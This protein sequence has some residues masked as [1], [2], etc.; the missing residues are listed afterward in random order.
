[1]KANQ[2]SAKDLRLGNNLQDEIGNIY[3]VRRLNTEEDDEIK[4][5]PDDYSIKATKAQLLP[6]IQYKAEDLAEMADEFSETNYDEEYEK[7]L[8]AVKKYC[9]FEKL[10]SD[11]PKLWYEMPTEKFTITK[12]DL[13]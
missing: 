10:N 8:E 6:I 7:I 13:L 3:T 1:M 4:D 5:L 9:D 12:Q 11:I 2:L